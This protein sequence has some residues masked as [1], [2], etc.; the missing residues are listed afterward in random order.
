MRN[1]A[2]PKPGARQVLYYVESD[3]CVILEWLVVNGRVLK[4]RLNVGEISEN[5]NIVQGVFQRN[6]I[7]YK[8][9][10]YY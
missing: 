1:R 6:I 9:H 7:Q 10:I 2:K 3:S 4:F 8:Y 5:S